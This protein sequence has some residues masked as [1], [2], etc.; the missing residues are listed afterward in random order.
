MS[1][2]SSVHLLAGGFLGSPPVLDWSALDRRTGTL[3]LMEMKENSLIDF[4]GSLFYLF[5][6][7]KND[8]HIQTH[9]NEGIVLKCSVGVG[10]NIFVTY[11]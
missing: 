7:I 2:D 4:T 8:S 5:M 9:S 10:K 6:G 11:N 3:L 1:S